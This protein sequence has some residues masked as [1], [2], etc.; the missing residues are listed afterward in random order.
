MHTNF[1][2]FIIYLILG[3]MIPFSLSGQEAFSGRIKL[4]AYYDGT[5]KGLPFWMYHNQRGR[6][7]EFTELSALVNAQYRV[8]LG[9]ESELEFGLGVAYDNAGRDEVFPDEVY[10]QYKNPW[11]R[12]SLGIKQ[13]EE[14]YQGL[15]ATNEN[16]LWS[17]NARPMP[18]LELETMGPVFF[19]RA[20]TWGFEARWAEYLMEKD[21][22]VE[23][24]KVHHKMFRLVHDAGKGWRFKVGIQHFAQWGGTSPDRGEQPEGLK[25]YIRIITGRNGGE[26][27]LQGDIENALGNHLGSWEL[28]ADKQ[29]RDFKLSFIY[30]NIFEDGSG[31][32]FANFPDG[33]YGIYFENNKKNRLLNAFIYELYYT[34]DQSNDVN[35][36]GA[37]NY[38]GHGMTY[39]SGWTYKS[40]ILGA[41]F[42]RY[43]EKQQLMLNNKFV[44]HH[45]GFGG[46]VSTFW[47]T[48]PYKLMLSY[49]HN[50]GTF[51]RDLPFGNEDVLHIFGETRFLSEPFQVSLMLSADINS[52]Y[53]PLFGVGVSLE[54]RF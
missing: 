53:N 40:R 22:H 39:N 32:R 8:E 14:H 18:G 29:F 34:R 21:R 24:A 42:F 51:R 6:V 3:S 12:V 45:F 20:E 47:N 54:R 35:R 49:A 43:D 50:E 19:N 25:D 1:K 27:A 13:K 41:P 4:N 33:R 11:L 5:E 26:E 31:S 23:N 2:N 30:N 7:S 15:S 36:W 46:Q 17:V 52:N 37:D 48:Y 9:M 10:V 44:T 16:I 28:Y 38:L